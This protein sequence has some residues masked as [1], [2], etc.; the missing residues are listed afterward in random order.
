MNKNNQNLEVLE[1]DKLSINRCLQNC[2]FM[3]FYYINSYIKDY[4]LRFL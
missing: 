4:F 2:D 3:F 1:L